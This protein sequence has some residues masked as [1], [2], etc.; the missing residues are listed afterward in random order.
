MSNTG[1]LYSS[2][3][4]PFRPSSAI[5][6][7]HP[8][9][10]G[11]RAV[12]MSV[13]LAYHGEL[14]WSTGA[15]LSL[16]Q[17][18]TLSGFLI[19]SILLRRWAQT[20]TVDLVSFWS[21][22]YR[23]L[24][25][26]ALLTLVGVILYG[27]TAASPYQVREIPGQ[28]TAAAF[29]VVNWYFILTEK[30]YIDLFAAPSP[31]QHFWSLAIEEQF[32]VL[33]PLAFVALIKWRNSSLS[34]GAFFL[35]GTLA[36]TAW[37]IWLYHQGASLDRL[38]Y[39]TD[40]RAAELLV[41]GLLAVVLARYPLNPGE[42]GRQFLALAGSIAFAITVW[43]WTHIELTD[44]PIWQ[45]GYTLFSLVTCVLIV[46]ILSGGPV[47]AILAWGF[48]PAM[49]RITYGLY[50]FHWPL[51]L[52]LD[53]EYTGLDGWALFTLRM[54]L[55]FALAIASYNLLEMP[56]RNGF[57][58]RLKK[59][60]RWTIAPA[61]TVLIVVAA[62]A[63]GNR[64]INEELSPLATPISEEAPTLVED[65]ILNVLVVADASSAKVIAA[66]EARAADAENLAV[67]VAEPF[68]CD[69][70]ATMDDGTRTC[71]EWLKEWPSL[72]ATVNPDVVLFF[73]N[74][75]DPAEIAKFS[76]IDP[77]SDHIAAT[78]WTESTLRGGLGLLFAQGAP[79]VWARIPSSGE[80]ELL[81]MTDP[82]INAMNLLLKEDMRIRHIL[83]DEL[84]AEID[85]ASDSF[86][87]AA[88]AVVL[89]S[90][91]LYRRPDPGSLPRV[92]VVGDSVARTFGYGLERWAADTGAAQ[93]WT[94]A[95]G[96][97]GLA[98]EGLVESW[99]FKDREEPLPERCLRVHSR[100]KAQIEQF[101]P[102]LVIVMTSIFD[103][104]ERRLPEWP[105]MKLP[106]DPAFD[107]YLLREYR[108]SVDVLAAGGAA[109][110]WIQPPCTR[111]MQM[112]ANAQG[113]STGLYDTARVRHLN[114]SLIPRLVEDRPEV[115]TYDLFPKL[116]PEGVFVESM[117]GIDNVRPDGVHFSTEGS[118]WLAYTFGG[119]M[120]EAG[121]GR[122]QPKVDT[123]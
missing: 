76:G 5:S 45:G 31:V 20:G 82:F 40:T 86:A 8:A 92:M 107:D 25:P 118:L 104:Q 27:A 1:P 77:A 60:V 9:L 12:A 10:D 57:P 78:A 87:P 55:T 122:D 13:V 120:L 83:L 16:S 28:V 23:R 26:A 105:Q 71:A 74:R 65:K 102:D 100:W 69:G 117:D 81:L 43:A 109:I 47:K 50:L 62:Y 91:E 36:S 6:S 4:T 42:R 97:C 80:E 51:F 95:T 22:R 64:E 72:V 114:Y 121:L 41:G 52:W 106:G 19:T 73:V 33:M 17:F 61:C 56:I 101:K 3:E 49:G 111:S 21:Q 67:T 94:T 89:D 32:Y 103:T 29:Q 75:W 68:R 34:I 39:G 35:F 48:L 11:L 115:R 59:S 99:W 112:Q 44:G 14:P 98:D 96:G 84:R 2:R 38:Y 58:S 90:L 37:M 110:L 30:S 46:S 54:A 116:C 79:V 18:F 53:E 93:V 7:Y 85:P 108:E 15:F 70:I 123:Q 63:A 113:T 88:L 119:E 66:L 24:M